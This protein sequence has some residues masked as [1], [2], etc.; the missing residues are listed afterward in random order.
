MGAAS[1]LSGSSPDGSSLC[2]PGPLPRPPSPHLSARPLNL[3]LRDA[4]AYG[5]VMDEAPLVA[6]EVPLV[7]D[8]RLKSW[9]KVVHSVDDSRSSGWAF[10]GEFIATGGIQDV[11]A[12]SVVIVYGEKGSASEPSSRGARLYGERRRHA[13]PRAIHARPGLG[14]NDPRSRCRTSHPDW[15]GRWVGARVGSRS[16]EIHDRG[17]ERRARAAEVRRRDL[18]GPP[19]CCGVG[20]RLRSLPTPRGEGA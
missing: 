19:A 7:G 1:L 20:R 2:G 10:N 14:Q 12:G 17:S 9:A 8:A 4:A 6:V 11:P 16:R 3:R 13:Q 5:D 18:S 15:A